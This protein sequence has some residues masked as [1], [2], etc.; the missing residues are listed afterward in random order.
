MPIKILEQE[1]QIYNPNSEKEKEFKSNIQKPKRKEK[2][3][4]SQYIING[5][6]C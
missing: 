5:K 1:Q 2:K 3:I 4:S 6:I